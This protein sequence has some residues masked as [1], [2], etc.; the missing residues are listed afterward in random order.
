MR[1][2]QSR[3]ARVAFVVDERA[4][5]KKIQSVHGMFLSTNGARNRVLKVY[6]RKT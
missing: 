6:A 4:V 1:G 3:L 2:D 5:K